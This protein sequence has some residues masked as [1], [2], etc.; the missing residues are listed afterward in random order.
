MNERD[1]V[2][3]MLLEIEKE[4]EFS[5]IL[6]R[7]VLDKYE[8]LEANKKRLIKRLTEG[9]IERRLELDYIINQFSKTKTNKMKPLIRNL[10]RMSVYQIMYMEQIPD[11][12]A[13]NEA[14][15]LA[16]L[17]KFSSLKGFVNGVLRSIVRSKEEIIYPS[18]EEDF[19][20]YLSIC[21]SLPQWMV[22]H[23]L[24]CYSKEETE[25]ICK[26]LL[27][28]RPLTVRIREDLSIEEREKILQEWE[29]NGVTVRRHPYLWYAYELGK[30]EGV[31]SLFG[32]EEGSFTVQDVSS[33]LVAE[34]AEVKEGMTILD[35]CAAPGGK[36]CH[37]AVKLRESGKV[38]AC[39]LTEYKVR[40]I[41]ENKKRQKLEQLETR[42]WDAREFDPS[43]EE[44][45][46]ILFCDLPCSGLGVIGK[47]PDIK[48]R[49][50]EEEIDSIA[51][52]QK[53]ILKNSLRYLKK[54]GTLIYSTCTIHPKE[55][56]EQV[57][58][59]VKNFD[60]EVVSMKDSLPS[61]LQKEEGKSGLQL[62]PGIHETDGFFL[63]K[64]R[65]KEG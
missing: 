21:Y 10:L 45:A 3:S 36:A 6:I 17:H 48:Y 63:A 57:E 2:L 34:A 14:V 22:K 16:A 35:V 27:E 51:E 30:T 5:H 40:M 26:G 41:E 7:Q 60:M 39:D 49:I 47:K 61:K 32:F 46:D 59:L 11:S 23:F 12:A 55:N 54:N 24:A 56:E 13:C 52:L 53:E 20:F 50:T 33:M 65:K 4:K 15:K 29:K 25:K 58:W 9:T 8:Y 1:I 37:A 19:L 28:E 18:R 38:I 62:L 44:T 31:R 42:V 43:L 64:L